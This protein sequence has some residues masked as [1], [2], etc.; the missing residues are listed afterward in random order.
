MSDPPSGQEWSKGNKT[1]CKEGTSRRVDADFK[2]T[3]GEVIDNIEY[4]VI[5]M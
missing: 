2:E 1:P 5:M 3:Q 4:V